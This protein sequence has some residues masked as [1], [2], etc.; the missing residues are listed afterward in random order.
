MGAWPQS[1]NYF[2]PMKLK[3]WISISLSVALLLLPGCQAEAP[4]HTGQDSP[5][6]VQES[7]S[8]KP[9]AE[10][11]LAYDAGNTLDP[12][13]GTGSTNLALAGLVY[14]GLFELD[15]TFQP[16]P[17]LCNSYT[18]SDDNQTWVFTLRSGLVFSNGTPLT[19]Q[20]VVDSLNSARF[21]DLYT[22]RLAQVSDI[23]AKEEVV[24]I[25]LHS[26]NGAFPALLDIPIIL[27]GSEEDPAPLGTG[28]Y[29]YN[30]SSG[31]LSL[32]RNPYWHQARPLPLESIP[33]RVCSTADDRIAAFDT[34]LV[35]VVPSNLTA[36]NALGYSGSHETWDCPTSSLLYLG[37]NCSQ[38]PCL[39]LALRQALSRGIN[40][41]TV[42]TSLLSS[43]ADAAVLPVHPV[44][45]LYNET[46]ASE[47][48]Y[49]VS[50]ATQLLE[51]G[52]YTLSDGVL[53]SN[54]R[55]V[56]L[57]LVVN[58]ENSFRIDV[59]D[60]LA[61]ELSKLGVTVTVTHLPWEEFLSVLSKGDFDLY[62][63]Q[64]K[65]TADFDPSVLLTGS[66]NY[67][68]YRSEETS[69]LLA[70]FRAA[71]SGNWQT[72][73]NALYANLAANAPFAPLCFLH[74]S[75]L[76][77]WGIVSGLE[78]TQQNPFYRFHNWSIH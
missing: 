55:P 15:P 4:S 76:T 1:S 49:S 43:H 14:E 11:A 54:G 36:S 64:V 67:G 29:Y 38:G 32:S 73:A 78:P 9:K 18:C 72:A 45:P 58:N 8:P 34:G 37:F 63:A 39:N 40:R 57:R 66:L 60:Y 13:S 42:V 35:S 41:S 31:N 21:S 70:A 10:F 5:P 75:V 33:L 17:L 48:D 20:H 44:S 28:P 19:A 26:P 65:L 22:A 69:A 46:L 53:L 59:A 50:A 62:L 74:S 47:L 12:L 77:Q 25:T 6:P 16:Q 3:P 30:F 68:A 27:P 51:G 23:T 2:E 71:S 24:T 7:S 52:G 61:E 56:E